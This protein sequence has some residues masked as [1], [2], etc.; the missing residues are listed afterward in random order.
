M[1]HNIIISFFTN[2]LL[3]YQINLEIIYE[4]LDR[5]SICIKRGEHYTVCNRSTGVKVFFRSCRKTTTPVHI[6]DAVQSFEGC[7]KSDFQK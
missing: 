2:N 3:L 6:K 7:H 1:Y 4:Q 5:E